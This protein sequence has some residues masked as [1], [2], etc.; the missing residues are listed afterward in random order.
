M[1]LHLTINPATF[2]AAALLPA[3]TALRAGQVVAYPTDTLYGL[4]ADPRSEVGVMAVFRIKG[5][6]PD[7]SLPLIAASVEQAAEAG[8]LNAIARRLAARFWPGPLTL[9]VPQIMPLA[10]GVGVAGAI[11]IRVPR[12]AIARDLARVLGAPITSTSA[13]RSGDPPAETAREVAAALGDLVAVIVDGGAA[14]GG[15]PSTIVD[16]TTD[17]PRLVRA[18]AVPWDRVL[19]SL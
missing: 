7:Q 9:V 4:G 2:D 15:A 11:A 14:P 10:P 18:G 13:N 12:D 3:L 8:E 6:D 19:E 16:V 1:P 17:V 5:R